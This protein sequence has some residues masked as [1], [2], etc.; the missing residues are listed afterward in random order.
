MGVA[1]E[2]H[3]YFSHEAAAKAKAVKASNEN[4]EKIQA[5]L[6]HIEHKSAVL[7]DLIKKSSESYTALRQ[8]NSI[9][10][11]TNP[12][13]N[14]YSIT[15]RQ[16]K[17]N[18]VEEDEKILKKKIESEISNMNISQKIIYL[19]K[20]QWTDKQIKEFLNISSGELELAIE[21]ANS[22]PR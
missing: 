15:K 12:Q 14:T 9:F 21:M 16:P 11:N 22:N 1:G 17:I 4:L 19:Q 7:N 8:E 6:V 5:T 2:Q 18:T 13:T 10:T 3:R 20:L